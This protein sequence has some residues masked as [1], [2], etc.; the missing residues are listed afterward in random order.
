MPTHGFLI[1]EGAKSV[2][3]S[4]DTGPTARLW[5]I[6]NSARNLQAVCIDTS[7]DNSLQEIADVSGHLTPQALEQELEKLDQK[8]P[9]LLHHLKPPCVELI[10]SEVGRLGNPDI[11]FLEQ[12][13]T[14]TF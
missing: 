7:F 13:K 1:E 14:Y 2:L 12:G 9:V 8:V 5:Q 4:S 11:E 3:W 10:R 6:A